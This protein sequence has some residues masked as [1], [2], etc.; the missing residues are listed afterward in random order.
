MNIDR[1]IAAWRREPLSDK[2]L[3]TH[4]EEVQKWTATFEAGLL[5][6]DWTETFAAVFVSLA[7]LPGL[8]SFPTRLAKAGA[9]LI[10]VHALGII[11]V[12]WTFRKAHPEPPRDVPLL[13][14]LAARR[15]SVR[16]QI[17]L[18]TATPWWYVA[19]SFA[20]QA[21]VVTGLSDSLAMALVGTLICGSVCGAV[22]W[23]NLRTA[24]VQMP[25]LLGEIDT[26]I[27]ELQ[28]AESP[29]G[30]SGDHDRGEPDASA[31]GA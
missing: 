10:I 24:R 29:P 1:A 16:R 13:E 27:R 6:R 20:G 26:A 25:A 28:D 14:F 12:L 23:V 3:S 15:E 9:L 4:L 31:P 19:P 30:P 5:R 22:V 11:V 17:G 18:L 8:I 21:L 2:D 7:F